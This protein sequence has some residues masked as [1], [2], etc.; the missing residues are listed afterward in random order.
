MRCDFHCH[1]FYSHDSVVSP[2]EMVEGAIKRGINCLAITDHD[3]IK[4]ALEALDY[5][6]GKPI[7]I[8]PG[9][10]IKSKAGDILALNVKEKIP[11][12]LSARET[13][14]R[15]KKLGGF[16]V[17]P[18]P[19]GFLC[20]FKENLEKLK[21]E[22]DAIEVVNGLI[23]GT[24]NKKALSFVQKHSFP[25]TVGGDAHSPEFLGRVWLEIEEK[26]FS[27]EKIFE[28]IKKREGK[29]KGKVATSWEKI[30]D[31]TK[32]AF[33]KI[34]HLAKDVSRKKGKI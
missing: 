20:S 4:G 19:F 10:E 23:F 24:G 26:D 5:A 13:I 34:N 6:R 3:E 17:I 2:K 31:H 32:R 12:R 14:W 15:I 27:V 11:S 25:F 8:I 16:V 21:E 9:I 33:S 29:I 18:H 28:K 1:T 30:I 7:L 22:I